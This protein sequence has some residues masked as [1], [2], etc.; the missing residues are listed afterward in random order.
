MC[1][2]D[3]NA[4]LRSFG[5]TFEAVPG[6]T[7][8]KLR[9]PESSLHV[10]HGGLSEPSPIVLHPDPGE[11]YSVWACA[12]RSWVLNPGLGKGGRGCGVACLAKWRGG[13]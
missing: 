12:A 8:F 11:A 6:P 2:R 5:E 3:R 1:I 4:P 13:V 10:R 7:Q 9:T